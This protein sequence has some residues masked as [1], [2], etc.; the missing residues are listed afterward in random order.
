[1]RG[2]L[3]RCTGVMSVGGW[4]LGRLGVLIPD[5]AREPPRN[6][7]DIYEAGGRA[8]DDLHEA[9]IVEWYETRPVT[10]STAVAAGSILTPFTLGAP[11]AVG[12]LSLPGRRDDGGPPTPP[13]G[14]GAEADGGGPHPPLAHSAGST[15]VVAA[16]PKPCCLERAM[17][18][19]VSQNTANRTAE[20]T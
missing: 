13:P 20:N 18:A 12:A 16:S 2:G 11:T 7:A 14:R 4:N 3:S 15:G 17:W 9:D 1:M 5:A 8:D 6:P 19:S 10:V